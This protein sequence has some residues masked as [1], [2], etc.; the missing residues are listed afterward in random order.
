MICSTQWMHPLRSSQ[1]MH[2]LKETQN[3]PNQPTQR[4]HNPYAAHGSA[5]FHHPAATRLTTSTVPLATEVH[6]HVASP[7]LQA[8]FQIAR[9]LIIPTELKTCHQPMTLQ[10]TRQEELERHPDY[11]MTNGG[12]ATRPMKEGRSVQPSTINGMWPGCTGEG[13]F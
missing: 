13:G 6:T 11:L 1:G 8:Q 4:L 7:A 5:P 10:Q 9:Q 12:I 3:P 2:R